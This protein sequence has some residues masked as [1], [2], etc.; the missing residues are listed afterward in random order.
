MSVE[1]SKSIKIMNREELQELL[2]ALQ[3]QLKQERIEIRWTRTDIE[4]IQKEL[5]R[6]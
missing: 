3:E 5:L 1:Q 2:E 4:R 6:C